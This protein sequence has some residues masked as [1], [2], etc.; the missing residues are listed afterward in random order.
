MKVKFFTVKSKSERTSIYIRFW[1]SN[2]I[3]LKTKTGL[4]VNQSDWNQKRQ[5]VKNNITATDRDFNNTKIRELRNFV[6]EKYNIDYN[7]N[8][9]INENWLK[10]K[11][12]DFFD[13][14]DESEFFKVY[15]SDWIQKFIDEVNDRNSKGS[16]Y[17]PVR[18]QRLKVVQNKFKLFE[19]NTNQKFKFSEID[20]KFYNSFLEYFRNIEKINDNTIGSYIKILKYWL[21]VA[22]IEGISVN[23]YYK[24]N[25]FAAPSNK[26]KDVYL[27]ENE[28]NS[29]Y[30]HDFSNS[31]RLDN[32]R[33]NF[34]IGLRTGLRISDFLTKLKEFNIN[35]EYIEIE[36]TKTGENVVIPLHPQ[37]KAIL[38]KRG[39][40]LPHK[41][42][43]PK[44]N[45]Y[46][47]EVCQE[48]GINEE[49]E[50]AKIENKKNEKDFFNTDIH[51]YNKNRKT[52]GQFPKYELITS[53]TCRRSFA[54]NL[55]GKIPNL[56][57]MAI[58]GH[59]TEA[60]F[61]KYI[62]ITPK[63]HAQKLKELWK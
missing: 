36:T 12:N 37:I 14:K 35:D 59:K 16:K 29:I 23:P 2:R 58:T 39:G 47:K 21:K 63:E 49:V 1:D 52:S 60:Q 22:E 32:T 7:S 54:S 6:L 57:I 24:H 8:N 38:E 9:S 53:H 31:E 30:N 28:I 10:T 13:R 18:I 46:I 44:F 5:E 41:I 43:D 62:K 51:I 61:L 50:G 15:F 25:D 20:Y 34:I 17:T 3:D 19:E 4:T 26:T 33:D 40:K 55:Y 11:V 27:T 42:S 48:V 45:K 56:S